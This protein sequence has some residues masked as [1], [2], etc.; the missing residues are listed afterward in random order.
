MSTT[1]KRR[2]HEQ[3]KETHNLSNLSNDRYKRKERVTCYVRERKVHLSLHVFHGNSK[4]SACLLFNDIEISGQKNVEY[5]KCALNIHLAAVKERHRLVFVF[6][7][8]S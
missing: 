4:N 7:I 3:P 8:S 1:N 5:K 6:K 2:R